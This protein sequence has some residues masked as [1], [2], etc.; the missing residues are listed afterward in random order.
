MVCSTSCLKQEK[1]TE[2]ATYLERLD[3]LTSISSGV[4][5]ENSR[6]ILMW[7]EET[8]SIFL[9]DKQSNKIWSTVPYEYYYSAATGVADIDLYSTIIIDYIP[10]RVPA[11][12]TVFLKAPPATGVYG[13]PAKR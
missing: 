8:K 6:F 13:L 3:G 12:L 1:I 10:T 2:P 7:D 4:G 11:P 5:A 9:Q